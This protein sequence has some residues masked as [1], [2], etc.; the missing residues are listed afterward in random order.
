M[1]RSDRM[2]GWLSPTGERP[3]SALGLRL[4]LAVFGLVITGVCAVI[5]ASNGWVAAAILSV[6]LALVAAVDLVVVLRRR[7]SERI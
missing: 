6:V 1:N 3:R 4:V 7:R 2:W 5:A